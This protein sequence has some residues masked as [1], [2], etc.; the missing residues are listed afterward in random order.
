MRAGYRRIFASSHPSSLSEHGQPTPTEPKLVK[1]HGAVGILH[2]V[3]VVAISHSTVGCSIEFTEHLAR[4]HPS[5]RLCLV[6]CQNA[7][8][9]RSSANIA[10]PLANW[11]S[12]RLRAEHCF[13]S[14]PRG[15]RT[16]PVLLTFGNIDVLLCSQKG[17]AH[18]PAKAHRV[19]W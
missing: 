11:A 14:R 3:Q 6:P 19:W 16:V 15:C 12:S 17:T 13:I 2:H 4:E 9:R 10:A 7:A 18:E 1:T 8:S 5:L